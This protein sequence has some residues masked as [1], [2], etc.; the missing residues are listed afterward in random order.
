MS[1]PYKRNCPK[2]KKDLF[3]SRKSHLTKATKLQSLCKSCRIITSDTRKKMSNATKGSLNHFYGKTHSLEVR[4]RMSENRAKQTGSK[5]PFYGKSH[6][7]DTK[8]RMSLAATKRVRLNRVREWPVSLPSGKI[9][10]VHGYERFAIPHLISQG[11][12]ENDLICGVFKCD[13]I[14]Y[15]YKGSIHHYIPDIYIKSLNMIVEVKSKYHF[16][17]ELERNGA[18]AKATVE[19]GYNFRLLVFGGNGNIL[20]DETR[21]N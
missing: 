7:L 1:T 8:K 12:Q 11:V 20:F 10:S 4:K 15:V 6:S 19:A 14:Q 3:Y 17:R 9:I 5:N 2:C 18:K 16:F 21:R 13:P